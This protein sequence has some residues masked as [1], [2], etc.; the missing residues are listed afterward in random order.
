MCGNRSC[1]GP[2]CHQPADHYGQHRSHQ[3][4]WTDESDLAAH[5]VIAA[6]TR[7]LNTET[8]P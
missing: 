5:A 1:L 4:I 6:T 8:T 2:I 7:R 3:F